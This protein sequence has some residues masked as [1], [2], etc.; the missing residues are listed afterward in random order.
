LVPVVCPT[1]S[2]DRRALDGP[3][4]MVG[5]LEGESGRRGDG[6]TLGADLRRWAV[7]DDGVD[8]GL[9]MTLRTRCQRGG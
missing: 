2:E 3:G 7:G 1:P 5:L 9:D 6:A 8:C 4:T